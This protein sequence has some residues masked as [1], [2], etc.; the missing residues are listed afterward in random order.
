MRTSI[1]LLVLVLLQAA[2]PAEAYWIRDC[3]YHRNFT[4]QTSMLADINP[5]SADAAEMIFGFAHRNG[6]MAI[7]NGV[8]Y[9]QAN[10]GQAG[11]ELW[12]VQSGSPAMVSDLVPGA[13]G[14]TPHSF[15][16]FQNKL[17]FAATTP[18][19]GEE[20]F[21]FDGTAIALASD[22]TAGAEGGEITALAVYNGALY[23]TR[24]T[25]AGQKVWRFD[26]TNAQLVNA[27]SN[28][29]DG[30]L[31]ES[32]FVVFNGKLYWVKRGGL[33]DHFQ[34]WA[35]DGSSAVKIKTLTEPNDIVEYS[36]DLGVYQGSLYFG[37][38]AGPSLSNKDELW[39][40]SGTGVP[41]KV[42]TLGNAASFTQPD[43]FTVFKNKLY[44]GAN[45]KFYRTDGTTLT[46][47]GA[48]P[49]GPPYAAEQ[50]SPFSSVDRLFF[51]GFYDTWTSREPYL[52]DGTQTALLRDIMPND[53]DP[54][55]G[56]F[57]TTAV[58]AGDD[59]Y[60]YAA[61][62]THGRELWR[63]TGE[64]GPLIVDCDI[65]VAPIWVDKRLWVIRDPEVVVS[66]W[67]VAP[68][69]RPRLI[70]REVV[71]AARTKEIRLRVLSVDTRRQPLPEGFA[72]ATL[73]F[74]RAT[75]AILDR[76]FDVVGSP[77]ARVR[78]A[79]RQA[80]AAAVANRTLKDVTA[81]TVS[82]Y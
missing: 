51:T 36:F 10:N 13:D 41:S 67:I 55:A 70:S 39:K 71:R 73:V 4:G 11:S 77:S 75:G 8:L 14:S 17:Y 29:E 38:V 16:V 35:Y 56:S 18:A 54:Y 60:F 28:V 81:E 44:F 33:A 79:L 62:Q 21:R 7:Y 49:G 6:R 78:Q 53:A 46:D 72:L 65:V 15:A 58:M 74:N 27:I 40:Y 1:A 24:T 37:V 47:L 2:A 68:E 19:T 48:G 26:G 76:G 63:A 52:F 25:N 32:P 64:Q 57:P 31:Y 12:R 22:I 30:D 42:A 9:F 80:A 20:L 66:T 43:N 69:A 5:G 61:D 34:L 3:R 23:F 45:G 59:L 50:M 82:K